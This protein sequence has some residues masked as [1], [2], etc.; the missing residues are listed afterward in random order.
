MN[1]TNQIHGESSVISAAEDSGA[2]GY[3]WQLGSLGLLQATVASHPNNT[4]TR[5]DRLG[6]FDVDFVDEI[7]E[8]RELRFP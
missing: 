3:G 7:A 2:Q 1:R 6:C 4:G 8:A 5:K